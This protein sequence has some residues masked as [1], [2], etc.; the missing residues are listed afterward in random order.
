MAELPAL[1]EAVGRL[2]DA[3]NAASSGAKD[4]ARIVESDS[5]LATKLLRLANSAAYGQTDPIGDVHRATVVLGFDV[6]RSMA[7]SYGL[8]ASLY[9]PT[10][11]ILNAQYWSHTVAAA[12]AC[13]RVAQLTRMDQSYA[14][15]T[16]GLLHDVGQAVFAHLIP[17][18]Y[19]EILDEHKAT[20]IPL[21]ILEMEQLG[22]TH[23]KIGAAFLRQCNM[24]M[25]LIHA[26][27]YH[28][29]IWE[30][31]FN[32]R[33][34]A[35]AVLG[36]TA[37]YRAGYA[38]VTGEDEDR[39]WPAGPMRTLRLQRPVLDELVEEIDE[40]LSQQ[41]ALLAI[42]RKYWGRVRDEAA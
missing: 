42:P 36:D 19:A 31:P 8:F 18:E 15:Y 20:Y 6:V 25:Y 30:T 21:S 29:R 9:D 1:P 22:T 10:E 27:E 38:G 39:E 35:L 26:V 4:V 7:L 28:H 11:K 32:K 5:A 34:P 16:I 2:L 17:Y 12:F 41:A 40:H 13:Q 37:A 24:P 14:A 3:L 23:A 33:Y